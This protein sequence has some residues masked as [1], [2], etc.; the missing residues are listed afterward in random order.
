LFAGRNICCRMFIG[1]NPEATLIE[2]AL[3]QPF[4][5]GS[6]K[7]AADGECLFCRM[8]TMQKRDSQ[9]QLICHFY[10]FLGVRKLCHITSLLLFMHI[11]YQISIDFV[12]TSFHI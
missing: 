1:V 3:S 11:L 7:D 4:L 8:L 6:F 5:P 12:K 9:E 10:M 2:S